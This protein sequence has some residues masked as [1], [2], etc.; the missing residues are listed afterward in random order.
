M[1]TL[2]A[3][4]VAAS[5]LASAY[6]WLTW[7][8]ASLPTGAG[9]ATLVGFTAAFGVV[10]AIFARILVREV[11]APLQALTDALRSVDYESLAD[12]L[13][14]DPFAVLRD[15]PLEVAQL[16]RA[17][18]HA[19][20]RIRRDRAQRQTVLGGLVHDLKTPALAQGHLLT[21]LPGAVGARREEI[22]ST[23]VANASDIVTRLD[24]VIDVLR[25]DAA[26]EVVVPSTID[27]VAIVGDVVQRI[28][29][30][31][32]ANVAV[33]VNGRGAASAD[34]RAL[35]RAL[36]NVVANAV[37][38]ARSRVSVEV[39]PGV[40]SV[41]DDG[42]GFG[43]P[44]EDAVD[45]FRP[46]PAVD[47]RSGTAGLGLYVARRSLEGFGGRLT[48]ESSRPGRTVLVMY[49]PVAP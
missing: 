2:T 42:P 40:V 20:E 38:F 43:V 17:F 36:E 13:A 31:V 25:V 49:H 44:F 11:V 6:W 41:V 24:R 33:E 37:R 26:Q 30:L 32:P 47:G 10:G 23:A 4:T 9:L 19:L 39:R 12:P 3:L 8:T 34:E 14:I 22:T 35:E 28:A 5:A 1:V 15:D 7:W 16:K 46:G 18:A 27:L 21:H 45:P 29:G 48:L